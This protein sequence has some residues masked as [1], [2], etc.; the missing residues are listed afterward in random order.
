MLESGNCGKLKKG[1]TLRSEAGKGL[2]LRRVFHS[3]RQK[4]SLFSRK[5][6]LKAA[7]DTNKDGGRLPPFD[8][9]LFLEFHTVLSII[10]ITKN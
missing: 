3:F 1:L 6:P 4:L 8:C 7:L 5:K 10:P 2:T 9:V